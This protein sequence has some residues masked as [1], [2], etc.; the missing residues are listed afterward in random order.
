MILRNGRCS[1]E[2]SSRPRSPG[3]PAPRSG[4][5]KP[6]VRPRGAPWGRTRGGTRL[7]PP[8]A[9]SHP[10]RQ[11]PAPSGRFRLPRESTLPPP[12]GASIPTLR[13]VG[14]PGPGNPRG[15]SVPGRCRPAP[16]SRPT[17]ASRSTSAPPWPL[18]ARRR[19]AIR[20][21]RIVTNDQTK[22]TE[23]LKGL[24]L[25]LRG[26]ENQFAERRHIRQKSG[27]AI[28]RPRRSRLAP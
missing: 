10:M 4:P 8:P 25:V 1:G 19:C 12:A 2:R 22:P 26:V 3:R 24:A 23:V 17:V 5:P 28:R 20:R 18:P 11:L 27:P 9:A 16:A 15:L 21:R 13:R 14:D 6:L 7:L